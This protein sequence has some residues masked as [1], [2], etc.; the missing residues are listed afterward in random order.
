MGGRIRYFRIVFQMKEYRYPGLAGATLFFLFRNTSI[1]FF[2]RRPS[3]L[4]SRDAASFQIKKE[5]QWLGIFQWPSNVQKGLWIPP[6][7]YFLRKINYR[8]A[9]DLPNLNGLPS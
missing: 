7:A 1:C 9:A 2:S 6:H 5:V 8:Y 4:V 3:Q